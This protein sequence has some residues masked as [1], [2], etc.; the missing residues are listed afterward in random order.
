MTRLKIADIL[1]T[2]PVDPEHHLD[3]ERIQ[4]YRHSIDSL[5]PVVVF[6]TEEGLLLADGYHR[7]A[8]A[9][10]EGRKTVEVEVRGGSRHDALEYAAAVGAAQRR[11]SLDEAKKHVMKWNRP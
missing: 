9:L 6:E 1:A 8:A 10:K 5:A 2:S 4:H 7:I 11:V 3:T